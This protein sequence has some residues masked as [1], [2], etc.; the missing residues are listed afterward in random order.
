[1]PTRTETIKRYLQLYARPELAELYNHDMECQVNVE[2][3]EGQP[4][5]GEFKGK[6]WKAWTDGVQQWKPIRIPYNASTKAEYSDV[7]MTFD[8]VKHAQA[9]GM[10]GWDWK[11]SVSR[12]VAFDFDAITGH[13]DKH[14]KKLTG[15]ELTKVLNAIKSIPWVEARRSSSGKGIHLYIYLAVPEITN[16]HH[17]HAAVARSILGKM[18]AMAGHD[19]L[20]QVDICGGNMW[21]WHKKAQGTDGFSII[22]QAETKLIEIP[23]NWRDHIKVIKGVKKRLMPDFVEQTNEN[24]FDEL[25]GQHLRIPLDEEHKK[26]IEWLRVRADS[27]WWWDS[28]RHMLVTHT[29]YLKEAHTELNMRGIFETTSSQSTPHNCFCFPLRKGAWGIRR[30]S[31]GC[32]EHDSW[33]Q[34]REGWTRCFLNRDPD[35]HTAA[36]ANGGVEL[37]NNGGYQF[38]E[39][40]MATKTAEQ[41]GV[42]VKLNQ[43]LC[44]R[45]TV[46][47][48]QKDGR[49]VMEVEAQKGDT[50]SQMFGWASV[51]NKWKKVF[52]SGN[53]QTQ[54]LET[55]T[56]D[57]VV[58]HTITEIDRAN[59]GWWVHSNSY[60]Q[61]EPIDHVRPLL[62]SLG[63]A[64]S[65]IEPM[66][67]LCIQRSWREV[68]RPFQSEYIG[69]R[70]WNRHGAQL[71]FLPNKDKDNLSYPTWNLVFDHLG[72]SLDE[73]IKDNAWA[74]SNAI[75]TGA[76]Y[77]KCWVASLFQEPFEPL[78]YLF[79][80][81]PQDCGKSVFHESLSTLFT[82]GYMQANAALSNNST[83]NGELQNAVLC[84]IE[85]KDLSKAK[86]AYNKVKDW[87]T[88]KQINIHI[89]GKTPFQF[90]NTT[91]WIQ[92][93]NEHT[94]CPTFTGDT[95]ITVIRVNALDPLDLIPRAK[96]DVLLEKE[97]PD[98][99]GAMFALELPEPISRLN[100]PVI[101]TSEK[102]NLENNNLSLIDQFVKECCYA[103]PGKMILFVDVYNKFIDWLPSENRHEWSR[104]KFG[105]EF[106]SIFP[107]GQHHMN[108]TY[109]GNIS[110]DPI[111]EAEKGKKPY[112]LN[113]K[114]YIVEVSN[115]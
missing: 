99:L 114:G 60:W 9:I 92:T 108:K 94:Y 100:I 16:N 10:T 67:G 31:P 3:G 54:E 23:I 73:A 104:I 55:P 70:D 107:K 74:R 27:T 69:N 25:A 51:G 33:T 97:A 12:W 78:P 56:C 8:L 18:S 2:Q 105:R 22:K 76:D 41:L 81:G 45:E 77:L 26:L 52:E 84:V 109:I 32:Q 93:A 101:T 106:P 72:K 43:F 59:T 98:F 65:M 48:E 111:T 80:F 83:F 7:Q 42:T 20:S 82:R 15:E 68:N 30:F 58:R 63:Y 87:V 14:T 35:L 40:E 71:K 79:F 95:R 66:L 75:L 11:N 17:E 91:H 110:F 29:I 86:E 96:L 90:P 102:I 49:V 47:K 62:K 46:L 21:V 85:E 4:V 39:A 6:A 113:S 36:R 64:N 34:D 57:D 38:R 112:T 50:A 28:D 53:K 44:S 13:S 103:V 89:K 88:G 19:F 5:E 1:M 61:K 24:S 115:V 37:P